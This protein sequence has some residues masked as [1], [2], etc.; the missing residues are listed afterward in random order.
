M[1]SKNPLYDSI[2]GRDMIGFDQLFDK[3]QDMVKPQ[4]FP[5]FNL[6]KIEK[7]K[8]VLSLAVAGFTS[9]ELEVSLHENM[10]T[11]SGNKETKEN[12]NIVYRGIASRSF[13]RQ[14]MLTD[15]IEVSN[16]ELEHGMLY[17]TLVSNIVEPTTQKF[18]IQVK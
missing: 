11:V 17:I 5:P 1:L 7:N 18:E 2:F 6:E 8:Y 13:K 9:N 4:G 12:N 16:V 14:W 10:L 15:G 3:M